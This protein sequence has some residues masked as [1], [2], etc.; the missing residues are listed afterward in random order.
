VNEIQKL[1]LDPKRRGWMNCLGDFAVNTEQTRMVYAYKYFKIVKFFDLE[2][3]TVR[4]V[5][6]E[7]EEFDESSNY[8]IDGLDSNVTHYRGISAG[9]K[10][11]Y[12][13]YIG[14]T[15]AQVRSDNQKENYYI[16]V[17]KY[18]WNGNPKVK[19]RLDRRGYFAVDEKHNML[20]L[21]STDDDDP[22]FRYRL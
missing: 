4:T 22:F 1:A 18:D 11:V 5:N 2:H 3:H 13:L 12:M 15:P 16:F 7:R 19:Y 20:Y 9:E 17:E 8:Q 6:F 14:R 10:Y 21:V